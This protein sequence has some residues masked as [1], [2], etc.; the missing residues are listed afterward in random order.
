MKTYEN[1]TLPVSLQRA[2]TAMKFETLT[3]IQEQAI[4]VI[5]EKKDLIGSAQTGT[6]KT[7]AF[8]IPTICRLLENPDSRA[9]FL[10]PTRELAMQIATVWKSMTRFNQEL[11]CTTLVGGAD[12][13]VQLKS[14]GKKPRLLIATPGRLIDHLMRKTVNLAKIEVLVLDEADRILDMGFAPQLAEILKFLPKVRQTLFF[15]ATWNAKVAELS[16]RYLVEPVRIEIATEQKTANN[17]QQTIVTTTHQGK[18]EALLDEL[19]RRPGSVLVFARTQIRTDRVAEYLASYGIKVN[20]LHGGRSQG[21][22]NAALQAFRM[23]N[24][25]VLVATDIA[26]RGI[27]VAKIAHVINYDLPQTPEDYVHRI[28]RTGRAGNEGSAV[29]LLIPEDRFTWKQI[30]ALMKKSGCNTPE[31]PA[32]GRRSA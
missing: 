19:N 26:A 11:H 25:R 28:G 22:R 10:V 20:C 8:C 30:A 27:D 16:K 29:S 32:K 18:N 13:R 4:P 24:I 15:T 23:G 9:L 5:L 12:F 21:Q 14:L 17:I 31:L 7:A 3:P 1:I 6:G 2:L